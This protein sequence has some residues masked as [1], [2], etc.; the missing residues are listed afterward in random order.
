M[1]NAL[2]TFNADKHDLD[3]LMALAAFGTQLKSTFPAFDLEVPEWLVESMD[4]IEKEIRARSRDMLM[5][6]L[7]STESRLEALKTNEEK[8]GDLR[9]KAERLRARL[10]K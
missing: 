8:R 10:K 4:G 1:L 7:K 3:E 6:E 2:Q 5:A 9:D